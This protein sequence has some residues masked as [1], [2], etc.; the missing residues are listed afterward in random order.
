LLYELGPG[1]LNL[2]LT[3][4][5]AICSGVL[6]DP[7]PDL[8]GLPVV[9]VDSAT[10]LPVI[11]APGKIL[12]I[13]VNYRTHQEETGRADAI[14]PV[15]FTRFADTLAAAGQSVHIPT[16]SDKYDYEGE[17]ALVIGVKAD[18]VHR[19]DAGEVVAGYSIFNDLSAR[20]WQRHTGQ[21]VPGKN[22]PESGPFGPYFVRA[23]DI[24]DVG[25][26]ALETRVNGE[27]RQR[28]AV[29]SLIFSIPE[30]IEYCTT[31]T[32]LSPGDVIVTGTP[33][34]VGLFQEPP[35]FLKRGDQV[36]VEITGLGTLRNTLI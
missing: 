13:G 1:G 7:L 33:G 5:D 35:V 17:L 19:D 36:E 28:A 2:A 25:A 30:I 34:G 27:V 20:D 23:A 15:V 10:F 4:Q 31:F 24:D 32:P 16:E 21:W 22:F 6:A 12:C 9:A 8:A 14:A 3:L 11:S 18:H 26:L 29:S